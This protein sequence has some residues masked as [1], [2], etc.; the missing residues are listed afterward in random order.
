MI[1]GMHPKGIKPKKQ[2]L[3]ALE[4]YGRG[5]SARPVRD[6][7]AEAAEALLERPGIVRDVV[8]G[9]RRT[10]ENLKNLGKEKD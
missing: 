4:N 10:I 1:S 2:R 6:A 7:I 3:W 5:G 9:T 8:S